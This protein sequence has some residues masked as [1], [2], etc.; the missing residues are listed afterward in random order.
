MRSSTRTLPLS[1]ASSD[2]YSSGSVASVRKPRLP[3]LTPRIGTSTPSVTAQSAP[4]A[5]CRRRRERPAGRRRR[6]APAC[7]PPAARPLPASAPRWPSR[8]PRS[9]PRAASQASIAIR[10]GVASRRC[11]LATMPTRGHA[12]ILYNDPSLLTIAVER[13][14]DRARDPDAA[15]EFGDRAVH[16][17]DLGRP[18]ADQ[19]LAH[20]GD[21]SRRAEHLGD[22]RAGSRW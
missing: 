18:A 20:R 13:G 3:K 19:I 11:D 17:I 6:R 12:D 1:A 14:V 15:P 2:G 10:C 8:R 16:V 5:A 9:S 7:P 22:R 4:T 21:G